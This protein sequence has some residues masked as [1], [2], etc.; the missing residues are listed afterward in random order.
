MYSSCEQPTD[1]EDQLGFE[2]LQSTIIDEMRK[3]CYDEINYIRGGLDEEEANSKLRGS[4]KAKNILIKADVE[5]GDIITESD[6]KIARVKDRARLKLE[7]ALCEILHLQKA[8]FESGWS[9][10]LCCRGGQ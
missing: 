5:A 10:R 1:D 4:E 6:R 8:Q 2:L 9:V 7:K 3:I